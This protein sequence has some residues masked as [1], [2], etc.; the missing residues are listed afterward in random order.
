MGFIRSIDI[1]EID[2]PAEMARALQALVLATF[3]PDYTSLSGDS[4]PGEEDRD[5]T[6]EFNSTSFVI[7]SGSG[8][9]NYRVQVTDDASPRLVALVGKAREAHDLARQL[10]FGKTITALSASL[11]ILPDEDDKAD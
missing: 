9:R 2:G 5:R 10:G 6:I 7:V 8:S 11:A 4:E 1:T 3:D